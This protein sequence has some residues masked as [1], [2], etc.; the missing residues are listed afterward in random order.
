MTQYCDNRSVNF[1]VQNHVIHER[2][3][4]IEIICHVVRRNDDGI[5]EPKYVSSV[6]QLADLLTKPLGRSQM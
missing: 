1:F 3:K 2:T 4:H 6:N 5:I